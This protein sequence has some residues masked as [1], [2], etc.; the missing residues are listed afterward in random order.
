MENFAQSYDVLSFENQLMKLKNILCSSWM[1]TSNQL[2]E[3]MKHNIP[4]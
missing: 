2:K 1:I 4:S 3:E